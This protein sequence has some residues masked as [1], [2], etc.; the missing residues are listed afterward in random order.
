[1]CLEF[2]SIRYSKAHRPGNDCYEEVYTYRTLGTEGM[3]SFVGSQGEAPGMVRRQGSKQ[4]A[5]AKASIVV[6]MGSMSK[7]GGAG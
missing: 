5:W 6:F 1:M 3:V 4:K 2:V 7:A